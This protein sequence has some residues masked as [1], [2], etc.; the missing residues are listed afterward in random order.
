MSCVVYYDIDR[1]GSC[2]ANA[3]RIYEF[4]PWDQVNQKVG[5]P[6]FFDIEEMIALI[7]IIDWMAAQ[8]VPWPQNEKAIS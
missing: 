4:G 2:T 3:A 8:Y 7:M 1:P 5:E 6:D